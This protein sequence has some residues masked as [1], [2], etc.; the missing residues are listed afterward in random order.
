MPEPQQT[1]IQLETP[2]HS[3]VNTMIDFDEENFRFLMMSG[4]PARMYVAP[5]KHAK[6]ILMLLQN[7]IDAYEKKYGKIETTLAKVTNTAAEEE[8]GFHVKK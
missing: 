5:P 6:R 3:L 1:Q 7:Q 2:F 4:G 8:V